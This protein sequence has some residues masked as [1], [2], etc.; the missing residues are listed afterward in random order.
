[1]S[2]FSVFFESK[3][4]WHIHRVD[5]ICIG[6]IILNH[7]QRKPNRFV[8]NP[9]ERHGRDVVWTC[10]KQPPSTEILLAARSRSERAPWLCLLLY[11]AKVNGVRRIK[12]AGGAAGCSI[13]RLETPRGPCMRR[14]RQQLA[15]CNCCLMP[16]WV[17]VRYH[18]VTPLVHAAKLETPFRWWSTEEGRCKGERLVWGRFA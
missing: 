12:N 7:E 9:G 8:S 1:M 15:S 17:N 3:F 11:S 4:S 13:N 6:I 14:L 5:A 2:W 18:G 16:T 10:L